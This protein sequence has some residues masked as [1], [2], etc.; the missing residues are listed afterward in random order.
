MTKS[1]LRALALV[2]LAAVPVV[3]A[4][5]AARVAPSATRPVVQLA[6]SSSASSSAVA[7]A[8]LDTVVLAGGCFWGVQGVFQHVKGVVSATSG[9]TGGTTANPDYE[10]VST[11][12]TGHAESVRVVY[13]PSK[14]SYDKLLDIFFTVVHDPTELNRQGPDA[15]TQYRSAIFFT[16]TAQHQATAKYVTALEKSGRY[17]QPIVT[18]I[19]A[20]KAFYTA[21]S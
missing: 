15:G 5:S 10:Q 16:S 9:Y 6:A 20:L 1:T 3:A 2:S 11:G 7:S 17:K 19:S 12:R 14:I 21:E 8:Q 18:Q 13:D 4:S